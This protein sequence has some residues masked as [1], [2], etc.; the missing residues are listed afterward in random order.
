MRDSTWETMA[1][2]FQMFADTL[3]VMI[4]FYVLLIAVVLHTA[5]EATERA[6]TAEATA[7]ANAEAA[8]NAAAENEDLENQLAAMEE[9]L[10]EAGEALAA[11]QGAAANAETGQQ[12]QQEQ[13]EQ[14]K[15]QL[16]KLSRK[17]VD[18]A[19]NVDGSLSM[20]PGKLEAIALVERI[21][22]IIPSVASELRICINWHRGGKIS[23][24]RWFTVKSPSEDKG[25]S[26]GEV[27]TYIKSKN[28]ANGHIDHGAVMKKAI[29]DLR[30]RYEPDRRQVIVSI[31]DADFSEIEVLNRD[32]HQGSFDKTLKAIDRW[33]KQSPDDLTVMA[34]NPMADKTQ[35]NNE[36]RRV[37]RV[38]GG[39]LV[40]NGSDL[41]VALT[42]AALKND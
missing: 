32:T 10:D 28:L 22:L 13:I 27:I 31:T 42:R 24:S 39:E 37:A 8:K 9:D 21:A 26:A 17:K 33:R 12:E 29:A 36:W 11:A 3:A 23:P 41:L 30:R 15:K 14:L 16:D 6:T 1:A 40:N 20:E 25:K 35:T 38:G 34:F 2:I 5:D 4:F 18:I 7:Q 19:L